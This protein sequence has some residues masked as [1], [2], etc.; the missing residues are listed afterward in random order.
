MKRIMLLV[1][2]PFGLTLANVDLENAIKTNDA[3]YVVSFVTANALPTKEKQ[4]FLEL[5]EENIQKHTSNIPL[6]WNRIETFRLICGLGT[7][8][9]SGISGCFVAYNLY[10]LLKNSYKYL[11]SRD[12]YDNDGLLIDVKPYIYAWQWLLAPVCYYTGKKSFTEL[13]RIY[14]GTYARKP[15]EDAVAIRGILESAQYK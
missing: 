2:V 4:K 9:L 7:G 3:K 6:R 12:G 8:A 1:C 15:Y 14:D 5:A 10:G 11:K 13:K